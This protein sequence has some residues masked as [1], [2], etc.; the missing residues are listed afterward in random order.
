MNLEPCSIKKYVF[1]TIEANLSWGDV[2][3][4]SQDRKSEKASIMSYVI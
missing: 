3:K 4:M 1:K 2:P